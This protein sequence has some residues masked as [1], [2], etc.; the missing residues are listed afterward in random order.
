[1]YSGFVMPPKRR[2]IKIKNKHNATES[3]YILLAGS[4][5]GNTLSFANALYEQLLAF[6]EILYL[7]E[8]IISQLRKIERKIRT[9]S[10]LILNRNIK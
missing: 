6:N 2:T 4:E 1:M 8:H 10:F 5:N 7:T 3:K 9:S